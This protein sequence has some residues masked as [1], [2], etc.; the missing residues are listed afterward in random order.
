MHFGISLQRSK[1]HVDFV[2]KN[3]EKRHAV[4]FEDQ[5]L[6]DGEWHTVTIAIARNNVKMNLDCLHTYEKYVEFQFNLFNLKA[7]KSIK[8]IIFKKGSLFL[9]RMNQQNLYE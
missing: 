7:K 8:V 9:F 4:N 5:R 1:I 2:R 3:S 6:I